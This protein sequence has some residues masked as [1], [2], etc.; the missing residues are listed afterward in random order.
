MDHSFALWRWNPESAAI[1]DQKWLK[2]T[3][4]T[5]ELKLPPIWSS[6]ISHENFLDTPDVLKQ[7]EAL[8][9]GTNDADTWMDSIPLDIP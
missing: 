7:M 2:E 8:I 4:N 9:T 3:L 1:V 5:V 6:Q